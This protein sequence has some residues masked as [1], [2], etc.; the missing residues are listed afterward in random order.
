[1]IS[2]V[3]N[4]EVYDGGVIAVDSGY[5]RPSMAACYLVESDAGVAIIET[6]TND[7]VP[8]LLRA[9]EV[10]GWTADDV[11]Y[12]IVTH[13]H[14]DHAGGAGSLMAACPNA[15]FLV[16]PRGARHMI[17][18]TRLEASVRQVYGN[19]VFDRD[20]G[21]LV[22]IP[23]ERTRAMRHGESVALDDRELRFYDTPGHARH[24]FCVWDEAT[25]GWFTGDTFGLSYRELDTDRG[26]FIFPTTTPIQFD[27]GALKASI[28][29]LMER[30]PAC[31]YLTHFGRVKETP[32]LAGDLLKRVDELVAIAEH[33]S[34]AEKRDK[35]MA[36]AMLDALED[37]ARAHG[38]TLSSEAFRA[39]VGDDVR[40]NTQGLEFWLDH[41]TGKE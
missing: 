14:L 40:L 38:V 26:A 30:S 4:T 21:T 41:R 13:V 35:V 27:P 20:Y 15:T 6:G 18:P 22:P 31:M 12:V 8:R 19:E 1:M 36:A 37:A 10:R 34:D 25:R 2:S 29:H 39:V 9:L 33:Y 28:E 3:V 7:S 23:E 11:R 17:D 5:H 32:R 16:H 24:H